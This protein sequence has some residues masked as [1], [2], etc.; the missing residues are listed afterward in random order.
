[1]ESIIEPKPLSQRIRSKCTCTNS[2]I[3]ISILLIVLFGT[4]TILL[5]GFV[6]GINHATKE[7]EFVYYFPNHKV[8][9]EDPLF[10]DIQETREF[11]IRI[12]KERYSD[13]MEAVETL[14]TYLNEIIDTDITK[15]KP[16][17]EI[18]QEVQYDTKQCGHQ[19]SELR[20]RVFMNEKGDIKLNA[21]SIDIN[22]DIEPKDFDTAFDWDL[23]PAAQYSKTEKKLEMGKWD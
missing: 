22:E 21:T 23:T 11:Q 6:L 18:Y 13:R 2:I 8:D 3:A 16:K 20:R 19:F 12:N 17:I 5:L 14:L 7:D 9:R 15:S 1:M 10:A 4:I